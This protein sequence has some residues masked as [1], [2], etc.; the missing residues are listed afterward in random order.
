MSKQHPT[1]QVGFRYGSIHSGQISATSESNSRFMLSPHTT[2]DIL[3]LGLES[4]AQADVPTM[5][6]ILQITNMRMQ[7]VEEAT[8]LFGETQNMR[9]HNIDT[10]SKFLSQWH[11]DSASG[12]DPIPNIPVTLSQSIT[13]QLLEVYLTSRP[14][15]NHTHN[16]NNHNIVEAASKFP[17]SKLPTHDI[18]YTDKNPIAPQTTKQTSPNK[19]NSPF[20][21]Q[22]H[23]D[24][25]T[26][27]LP[28]ITPPPRDHKPNVSLPIAKPRLEIPTLPKEAQSSWLR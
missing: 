28:N 1:P 11:N 6:Q 4:E 25:T 15:P 17:P 10:I 24:P 5:Q 18:A 21:N 12:S 20:K 22:P 7:R 13:L 3:A 23:P 19:N 2:S 14:H 27:P 9:D 16:T 26:F 8:T